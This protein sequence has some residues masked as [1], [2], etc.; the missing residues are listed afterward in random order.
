MGGFNNYLSDMVAF[1]IPYR[2]AGFVWDRLYFL[3]KDSK[4]PAN[5]P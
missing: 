1:G 3:A 4:Y 2:A 5:A